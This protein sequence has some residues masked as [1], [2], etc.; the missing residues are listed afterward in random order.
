MLFTMK[1]SHII[2]LSGKPGAG[3]SSTADKVAELLEYSRHSSGEMVRAILKKKHMTLEEYNERAKSE[4]EL[5]NYIDAELRKLREQKDIVVDARLGFYW[6]P[7]S[8]KVYLNLDL[9]AATVRIFNDMKSNAERASEGGNQSIES[10]AASV[11]RRM[12]NEHNRFK[13]LY[14]VDPYDTRNF[15]LVINTSQHTPQSVALA[16]VE[17]YREWLASE[18][19]KPRHSEMRADASFE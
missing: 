3:K 12:E 10:V 18:T 14:G 16:V 8:F 13:S 17:A 5:D 4:H 2:T 1:K 19:W 15:D 9:E 11:Q 7:E 6:I